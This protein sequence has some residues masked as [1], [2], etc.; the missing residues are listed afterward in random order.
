MNQKEK[1]GLMEWIIKNS[2]MIWKNGRYYK[3]ISINSL[4]NKIQEQTK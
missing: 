3:V 4:L 2:F 1:K